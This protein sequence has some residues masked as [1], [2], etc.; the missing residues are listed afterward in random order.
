MKKLKEL[1]V[2]FLSRFKK[3][4]VVPLNDLFDD[5]GTNKSIAIRKTYR[6]VIN[7]KDITHDELHSIGCYSIRQELID[8]GCEII[9]MERV[10]GGG[11]NFGHI[12]ID[13]IEPLKEMIGNYKQITNI[14]EI[15]GVEEIINIFK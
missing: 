10:V 12:S 3:Q 4:K 8:E 13:N 1:I 5:D 9:I 14:K 7:I 2:D 6:Y 15:E 11:F